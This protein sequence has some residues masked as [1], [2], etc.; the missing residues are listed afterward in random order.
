[1]RPTN[2][3]NVTM[4]VHR[5]RRAA[6]AVL[7]LTLATATAGCSTGTPIDNIVE[8]LLQQGVDQ[9]ADGIDESIRGLV[10]EVLGGVELTTDG[11]VPSTFPAEVALTGQVLGG[12]AGP[13][14]SG[15]VVRT[16][17]G[18]DLAFADAATALEAAGF[19]PSGVSSDST[20][21]YGAYSSAAYRVDLS[22]AAGADGVTTATYVVTPR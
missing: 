15:W 9:I 16:E 19:A 14:G 8:G 22:V 4:T 7:A 13:A 20:S 12:G 5:T 18:A 2:K 6:A 21:G 1:V 17:L 3:E 11:Q 10:G